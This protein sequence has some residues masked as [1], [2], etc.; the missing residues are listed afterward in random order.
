MLD[1]ISNF[2]LFRGLRR[3]RAA[4]RFRDCLESEIAEDFLEFLLNFMSWALFLDKDY[5]RNIKDFNGRY[6][7]KSKDNSVTV[8]AI[9]K[10]NRMRVKEKVIDNTNVAVI[11][12]DQRAL[13]K[14]LLSPRPD[15]LGSILRQDVTF[16]GNL[17][18]LSKFAYM[19][20]RLQLMVTGEV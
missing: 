20:R 5:K 17:I 10:N 4:K 2:L 6:L 19:A 13:M 18:Y 1:K 15:I 12:R 16:D 14:F 11:F 9:F 7:F 3:K 8:A